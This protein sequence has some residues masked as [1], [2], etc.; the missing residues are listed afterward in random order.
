MASLKE[1]KLRI[2]SVSSTRKIT[3]AM[4]LVASSKLHKAQ[5]AIENMR[6]YQQKMDGIMSRFVAELKEELNSGLAEKREVKKAVVV[7][8]SSNS[9]LCG[10]FNSN[11]VRSTLQIIEALKRDNIEVETIPIGVKIAEKVGRIGMRF[12]TNNSA[13]LDKAS[14]TDITSL[15]QSLISR[16]ESKEIDRV[17]L[18]YNHFKNTATQIVLKED[19]LPVSFSDEGKN[20]AV[21]NNQSL[22]YIVEP[23]KEQIVESLIPKVLCL[24]LYTAILDSLA[25][26]HS[27]RVVAMQTATDNA[28]QLLYELTLMYNKTR[29]AAITS[30]LLDIVGA[31]FQ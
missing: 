10:A 29:Q 17:I 26:E 25:A 27:A 13:L 20:A 1:V 16:Y 8:I 28:D 21:Q 18:I 23:S 14:Y 11:V 24:K 6:P 15:A 7:C 19:F 12:N 9:S 5:S 3:S 30:E 31:S 22:D 2:N 4:K